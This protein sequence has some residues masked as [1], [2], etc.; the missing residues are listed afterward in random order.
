MQ[1]AKRLGIEFKE[2]DPMFTTSTY[3][4][5]GRN[6]TND[7]LKQVTKELQID[8]WEEITSHC[9]RHGFCYMGLL[10]DVPLEYM[11]ILLRHEDIKVTRDWYAEFSKDQIRK[12]G[13]KVNEN[14]T[15]ELQKYKVFP[16]AVNI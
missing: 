14:R 12:F 11:S 6:D 9:L 16:M 5:L 2:T 4:Q 13:N 1:L 3:K 7:R 8:H 15:K 10:N